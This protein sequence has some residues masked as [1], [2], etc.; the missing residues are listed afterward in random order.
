MKYALL[1]LFGIAMLAACV[2]AASAST[3]AAPPAPTPVAQAPVTPAPATPAPATPAPAFTWATFEA[4]TAPAFSAQAGGVATNAYSE[5]TGDAK[6]EAPIRDGDTAVL[7]YLLSRAAGS[8][9]LG[10]G[11]TINA[12]KGEAQNLSGYSAIRIKVASSQSGQVRLRLAGTDSVTQN[13]GCYPVKYL[14]VKAQSESYSVP[15]GEF[16][17]ESYCAANAKSLAQTLPAVIFV[18][19]ADNEI[20]AA[21]VR[22]GT[23]SV[24]SIEF[25]K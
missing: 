13:N 2:P 17:A 3:P 12:P 18:E 11:M 10:A 1:A 9:Y 23:I 7:K 25:I 19:V 21:G 24:T 22:N 20:P 8:S 16:A 15:L 4:T 14:T 5:K 6:A